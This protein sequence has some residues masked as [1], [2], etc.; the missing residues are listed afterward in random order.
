ME[1]TI[2]VGAPFFTAFLGVRSEALNFISWLNSLWVAEASG[3]S[4]S[5]AFAEGYASVKDFTV[6]FSVGFVTAVF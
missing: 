3:G 5:T 2:I 6:E 1:S 4:F